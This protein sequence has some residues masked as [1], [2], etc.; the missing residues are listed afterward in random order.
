MRAI[1]RQDARRR[2]KDH[3]SVADHLNLDALSLPLALGNTFLNTCPGKSTKLLEA[4]IASD[5]AAGFSQ[6]IGFIKLKNKCQTDL[7]MRITNGHICQAMQKERDFF[8]LQVKMLSPQQIVGEILTKE[9][10]ERR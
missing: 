4:R 9:R 2:K 10:Q 6:G 8:P 7:A 5:T 1:E 3:P